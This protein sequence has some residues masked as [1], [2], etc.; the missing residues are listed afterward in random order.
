VLPECASGD[1]IFNG[2]NDDGS[3]TVSLI[4]IATA[5]A[6]LPERPRRSIVF[7]A[8]FGEEG[9][10]YGSRYYVRH[11]VF[12]L[13]KTIGNV[14]L[15]QLG[16]TDA[17]D[18]PKV[19]TVTFTGYD[20]SDLPRRFEEAGRIT[21]IKVHNTPDSADYFGRS[22]NLIFARAGIPAHTA[23]VAYV[24]PDYHGLGDTWEKIDYANLAAVSRALA[25]G[26]LMLAS[27]DSAP[28]W[29]PS[30]PAAAPYLQSR[31]PEQSGA[32]TAAP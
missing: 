12:P 32:S 27:G 4:E 1:C 5:L 15:E 24:Y 7:M 11:P 22:D 20:F 2:A 8:L 17:S 14:N 9:G 6:A 10:G 19:K 26:V 25:L 21:G 23:C 28:R 13:H 18:G 16:R 31:A 3:G 29:D 30:Q